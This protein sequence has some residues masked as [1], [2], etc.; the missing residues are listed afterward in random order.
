LRARQEGQ[1]VLATRRARTPAEERARDRDQRRRRGPSPR[2]RRAGAARPRDRQR[3]SASTSADAQEA[4]ALDG[5]ALHAQRARA[6]RGDSARLEL[7]HPRAAPHL[8]ASRTAGDEARRARRRSAVRATGVRSGRH[9]RGSP[10]AAP[11]TRRAPREAPRELGREPHRAKQG[12]SICVTRPALANSSAASPLRETAFFDV[13][14]ADE[15][16]RDPRGASRSARSACR[17]VQLLPRCAGLVNA[18]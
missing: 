5:R 10:V 4:E 11:R 12:K 7:E 18:L 9:A 8:D 3:D 1:R 2:R 16:R 17:L 15:L 6:S 13:R 14:V